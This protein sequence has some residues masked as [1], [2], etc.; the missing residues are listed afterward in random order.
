MNAVRNLSTNLLAIRSLRGLSQAAFARELDISKSTLQ[1]IEQ[2]HGPNLTTVE[3]IARRLQISA[4][5]LISDSI[6]PDQMEVLVRLLRGSGWYAGWSREDQEALLILLQQLQ[7]L[8]ARYPAP[9]L[10]QS[11]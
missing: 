6:P 5:L 2:G 10:T 11:L 7:Q 1:E 9:A 4:S 3:C 8:I